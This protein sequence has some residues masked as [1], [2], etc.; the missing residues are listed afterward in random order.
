V[1][2]VGLLPGTIRTALNGDASKARLQREMIGSSC[3]PR[4]G[5]RSGGESDL[6]GI[7]VMTNGADLLCGTLEA[8][9]SSWSSASR[10]RR[11]SC[12]TRRSRK[13]GSARC[14]LPASWR[15]RSWR[16]GITGDRKGG[17]RGHH[18]GSGF[19][20]RPDRSRRG[21]PGF[22]GA[23]HIVGKPEERVGRRY[24]FQAI[25]Q[26]SI[27]GRSSKAC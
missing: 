13:A 21:V 11:T 5:G 17:A 12:S 19:H 18:P 25:D 7:A 27:A 23:L 15:P 3:S 10:E 24:G 8:M 14:W 1:S 22:R 16:T 4:Q 6:R 26:A 9:G 2:N 20:L